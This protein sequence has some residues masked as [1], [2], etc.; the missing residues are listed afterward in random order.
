MTRA[1]IIGS[2][3]SGLTTAA[4][5]AKE[6]CAVQ[7]YEQ[8]AT[9]GGVTQTIKRDGFSWDMG[10]LVVEGLATKPAGRARPFPDRGL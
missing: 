6:G 5:L 4:Y 8:S 10:P 7:I 2:G 3:M 1:I 9:V